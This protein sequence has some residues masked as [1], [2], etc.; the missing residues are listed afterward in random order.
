MSVVDIVLAA[1]KL[2]VDSLISI[3]TELSLY[4]DIL[5][6]KYEG[7]VTLDSYVRK[8]RNYNEG[9]SEGHG[10]AMVV[11]GNPDGLINS[12][13]HT[14]GWTEALWKRMSAN[15]WFSN[16]PDISKEAEAYEK[17]STDQK[18]MYDITLGSLIANDSFQT[19]NLAVNMIG[20]ISDPNIIAIL[21][22]QAYEEALH[23]ESYGV[24][25][26]DV[27]KGHDPQKVF[28]LHQSDPEL[29]KRNR[30]LQ[31]LYDPLDIAN[32]QKI[33]FKMFIQAIA[34]N[35]I[36]EGIM[37]QGGFISVWSLGASMTGS[38]KMLAFISRD[39]RT[40]LAVFCG[41]FNG[42]MKDFPELNDPVTR[43]IVIDMIK[44]AVEVEIS[45]LKYT[46]GDGVFIFSDENIRSYIEGKAN[47]LTNAIG[48]GKIYNA[49]SSVLKKLEDTYGKI[50]DTRSNFFESKPA[51]Y[52]KGSVDMSDI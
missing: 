11:N 33:T 52:S 31:R 42:M 26:T 30:W 28:M 1:K 12:T 49:G 2:S 40:H 14:Q 51:A 29:A 3:I 7:P 38:S 47:E 46:T 8:Q 19:R 16:E 24:L 21:T 44:E 34:A 6:S 39:E 23:S 20:Y 4:V 32:G 50:D 13:K 27:Y 17:L 18:R 25:S 45:W 43:A 48:Y 5:I 37:F 22:R 41:I 15:T 36:L 10:N 35:L 9:S